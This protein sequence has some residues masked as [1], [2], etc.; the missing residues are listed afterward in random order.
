MGRAL[1]GPSASHVVDY[2]VGTVYAQQ[3]STPQGGY[4]MSGTIYTPGSNNIE[5]GMSKCPGDLEFYKTHAGCGGI[6]G[7]ESSGVNWGA[8]AG[9]G[10]RCIVPAGELWYINTRAYGVNTSMVYFWNPY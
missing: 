9:P 7:V 1:L 4:G 3:T 2:A 5:I 10:G 8:T 6:F